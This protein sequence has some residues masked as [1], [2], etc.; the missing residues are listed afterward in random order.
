MWLWTHQWQKKTIQRRGRTLYHEATGIHRARKWRGNEQRNIH[1]EQPTSTHFSPMQEQSKNPNDYIHS[2]PCLGRCRYRPPVDAAATRAK[3]CCCCFSQADVV[4]VLPP[5]LCNHYCCSV[6]SHGSRFFP[7]IYSCFSS[8]TSLFLVLCDAAS[9]GA[10]SVHLGDDA[11]W[12]ELW[13]SYANLTSHTHWVSLGIN[14]YLCCPLTLWL[15][16]TTLM[17]SWERSS[18]APQLNVHF[19]TVWNLEDVADHKIPAPHDL[20]PCLRAISK[21][22]SA[23]C[24]TI[25]RTSHILGPC[26]A[27]PQRRQRSPLDLLSGNQNLSLWC[28]TRLGECLE[29]SVDGYKLAES[30]HDHQ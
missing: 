7:F 10:E 3:S 12:P 17:M 14:A 16:P 18:A 23:W 25:R 8:S 30:F 15:G 11:W 6:P 27:R 4:E 13:F 22:S 29:I 28:E 21:T 24:P 1:V 19:L 9:K 20:T 26:P 5:P 2:S